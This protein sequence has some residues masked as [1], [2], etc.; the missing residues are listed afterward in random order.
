MKSFSPSFLDLLIIYAYAIIHE[1]ALPN[2]TPV[3]NY[4]PT[5]D[6]F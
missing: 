5:I 1:N 6:I 2:N 4:F 3:D